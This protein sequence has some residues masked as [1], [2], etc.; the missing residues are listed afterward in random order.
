MVAV[1]ANLTSLKIAIFDEL[2]KHDTNFCKFT[3]DEINKL[4]FR[5]PANLR[6]SLSGFVAIKK[7]FTA[8]SFEVPIEMKTRHRIGMSRMEFP[9]F[10]TVKRLVLFSEMDAMVVKMYGGIEGFLETCSRLDK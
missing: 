1:D 8:Y 3:N 2:R 4:L 9:Y 7:V 5:S 10:L 6:L